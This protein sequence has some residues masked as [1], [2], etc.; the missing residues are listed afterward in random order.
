MPIAKSERLREF[1]RRL[2]E[3]PAARNFQ[4]AWDLIASTL[5]EVE[6][7]LSGVPNNPSNWRTDGRMYPPQFDSEK[8]FA[9]H[10]KVRRFR[11]VAHNTLIGENGSIQIRAQAPNPLHG[12]VLMSKPGADGKEVMKQ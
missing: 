7:E 1:F 6:D 4:E 3:L 9:G 5:N 8:R 11:S 10:P 12:E 2:L